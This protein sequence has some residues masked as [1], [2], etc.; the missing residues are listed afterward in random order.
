MENK[1]SHTENGFLLTLYIATFFLSF[2]YYFVFFINSTFLSTFIPDQ[3][4]GFAYAAAAI[5]NVFLFL[6]APKLLQR[7][8]NFKFFMVLLFLEAT[9]LLGLAFGKTLGIV[10]P[11][12]LIHFAT[13]PLLIFGIDI[14]LKKYSKEKNVGRIRGVYLTMLNLPVIVAPFISGIILD[15]YSFSYLYITAF[16]LVIPLF[17]LI[18]F[19]F[20]NFEDESYQ[21]ISIFKTLK[22]VGKNQDIFDIIANTFLL[23][24]FYSWMAIYVPIYL[25]Q[26]VH[27][28]WTE[29]GIMFSIMLTPFVLFQYPLGYLAD[30][31]LGEKEILITGSIIAGIST[32]AIPFIR[33]NNFILWTVILFATRTGA[34]FI[35][36]GTESYF[37]KKIKKDD[38]NLISLFRMLRELPYIISPIIAF[39]VLAFLSFQYIF[40]VLGL[41]MLLGVYYAFAL[42][43]TR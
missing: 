23:N 32:L 16:I 36:L 7:Y 18:Y 38:V 12:F 31:K 1:N 21:E 11:L 29:I 10:A 40:I 6:S 20:K 25:V 13:N 14:F 24:F 35:E 27:F 37:F 41:L 15:K 28:T 39:F 26:F 2:H 4:V 8:G 3:Y 33:E 43:D 5:I 22:K 19:K 17:L 34:S 30:K 9:S 42:K